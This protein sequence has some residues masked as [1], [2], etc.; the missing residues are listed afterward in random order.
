MIRKYT[1]LPENRSIKFKLKINTLLIKPIEYYSNLYSSKNYSTLY[2][3]LYLSRIKKYLMA[4][5]QRLGTV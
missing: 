3:L 1:S 4:K 2:L 5:S